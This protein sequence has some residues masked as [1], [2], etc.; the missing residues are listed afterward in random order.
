MPIGGR[1]W[2]NTP[3]DRR[4]HDDVVY[5]VV[6]ADKDRDN[7][8]PSR[9]VRLETGCGIQRQ[10]E[11]IVNLVGA[12]AGDRSR[13][14]PRGQPRDRPRDPRSV[15]RQLCLLG[16]QVGPRRRVHP[17]TAQPLDRR[18]QR[19]FNVG[20]QRRHLARRRHRHRRCR[21]SPAV[22]TVVVAPP[23]RFVA[24][25]RPLAPVPTMTTKL[26]HI[27]RHPATVMAEYATKTGQL[28]VLRSFNRSRK[29]MGLRILTCESARSMSCPP[30]TRPHCSIW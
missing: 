1:R 13:G 4:I 27:R 28:H 6:D 19:L 5:P 3:Q 29:T 26:K 25:I 7:H 21:P 10:L 15:Q 16:E 18:Q 9:H 11:D 30:S 22:V 8:A 14:R 12:R 17:K 23:T 20:S 24:A 2:R